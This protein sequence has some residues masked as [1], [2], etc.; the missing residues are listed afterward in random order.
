MNGIDLQNSQV[1]Q[2]VSKAGGKAPA[3][4]NGFGNFASLLQYLT[5]TGQPMMPLEN[6]IETD[7]EGGSLEDGDVLVKLLATQPDQ[8]LDLLE[9]PQLEELKQDP[10]IAM[11]LIQLVKAIHSGQAEEAVELMHQLPTG[12]EQ[13]VTTVMASILVP[14]NVSQVKQGAVVATKSDLK[15][16]TVALSKENLPLTPGDVTNSN[17]GALAN[18]KNSL[19][20]H[21]S[22]GR[23]QQGAAPQ[24]NFN[25][26]GFIDSKSLGNEPA[27]AV[28]DPEGKAQP[29][30]IPSLQL[31]KN[32]QVL[33]VR[34]ALLQGSTIDEQLAQRI[35]AALKQA[36]FLKGADGSTRMSIRLYPEQL[37]EVVVQLDR[38]EGVLTVKLFAGTEQAKQ[39]MDQ[40]LGKLQS[41]LQHQAP[42]LKIETGMLASSVKE[43]DSGGTSQERQQTP[44]EDQ[45]TSQEEELE[46]EE[47]DG[48]N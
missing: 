4:A 5:T 43:F 11:Q 41:S 1:A 9:A 7:A 20:L 26:K 23:T 6:P 30:P 45:P 13:A 36:P 28:A 24:T 33:N 8:A 40:Q 18:V 38:K 17:T 3:T 27:K 2:G 44:H 22:S 32:N 14:Q 25:L 35:E 42:L 47:D 37:G 48:F 15:T 21:E 46:E 39:L 10:K 34:P 16:T 19:A 29:L 31:F 12:V